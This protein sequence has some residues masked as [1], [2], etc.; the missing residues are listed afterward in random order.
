M[1]EGLKKT[2]EVSTSPVT[3]ESI[4]QRAFL[5]DALIFLKREVFAK[6]REIK[7]LK[8]QIATFA[9]VDFNTDINEREQNQNRITNQ[10]DIAQLTTAEVELA[11]T[12]LKIETLETELDKI[13]QSTE[14]DEVVPRTEL[15]EWLDLQIQI[16]EN[17]MLRDE[18]N[19]EDNVAQESD[20]LVALEQMSLAAEQEI[21]DSNSVNIFDSKLD[22]LTELVFTLLSESVHNKDGRNTYYEAAKKLLSL[23]QAEEGE[24]KNG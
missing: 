8:E 3:L 1:G 7:T 21:L 5:T 15:N 18:L 17:E 2:A 12:I 4:E 20:N 23:W 24:K 14:E 10:I 16:V 22:A 19:G 6:E 13:A 11:E 9:S